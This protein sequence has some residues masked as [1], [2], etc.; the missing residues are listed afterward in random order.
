MAASARARSR[1]SA[2]LSSCAAACF[3]LP[4]G[5]EGAQF[6]LGACKLPPHRLAL[7]SLQ[8]HGFLQLRNPG[9]RR[10]S[11]LSGRTLQVFEFPCNARK[12]PFGGGDALLLLDQG[13]LQLARMGGAGI[14][15]PGALGLEG[16]K[17]IPDA[18][19]LALGRFALIALPPHLLL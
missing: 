13:L 19:Q 17:L 2:S 11:I 6:L 8:T 1:A 5:L 18:G 10:S 14:G 4:E 7:L 16:A 12:L 15:L 9:R 3:P